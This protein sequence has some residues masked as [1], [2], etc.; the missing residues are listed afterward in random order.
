M[1]PS[2]LTLTK[3]C[4]H[5]DQESKIGND[6]LRTC[7]TLLRQRLHELI[8]DA[9]SRL[10]VI[11]QI[12]QK[13][14]RLPH[15]GIQLLHEDEV[16][17]YAIEKSPL[18]DDFSVRLS[19][20]SEH[21]FLAEQVFS[22]SGFLEMVTLS[23]HSWIRLLYATNRPSTEREESIYP[24]PGH[25]VAMVPR[26]PLLNMRFA[27]SCFGP[28]NVVIGVHTQLRLIRDGTVFDGDLSYCECQRCEPLCELL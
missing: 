2:C 19:S 3:G 23:G 7:S 25:Q 26:L 8:R 13:T 27:V 5:R 28:Q 4:Y 22:L 11:V 6:C 16:W 10:P 20:E 1:D 15:L 14:V 24:I 9:C 18:L 21:R 17:T 12:N